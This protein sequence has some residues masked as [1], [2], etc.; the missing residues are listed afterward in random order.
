MLWYCHTATISCLI[1]PWYPLFFSEFAVFLW[2]SHI[3]FNLFTLRKFPLC[4]RRMKMAGLANLRQ[5]K[6]GKTDTR[7]RKAEWQVFKSSLTIHRAT[8]SIGPMVGIR[9]GIS[10]PRRISGLGIQLGFPLDQWCV[11][12]RPWLVPYQTAPNWQVASRWSLR[13]L[14]V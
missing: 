10:L 8:S 5:N 11:Y 2:S 1:L 9:G 7:W 13:F 14:A 3:R 12:N 6:G 4:V